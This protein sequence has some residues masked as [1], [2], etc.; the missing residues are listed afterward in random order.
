MSTAQ[1]SNI[2]SKLV[3]NVLSYPCKAEEDLFLYWCVQCRIVPPDFPI[4][5]WLSSCQ[6]MLRFAKNITNCLL[7]ISDSLSSDFERGLVTRVHLCTIGLHPLSVMFYFYIPHEHPRPGGHIST[8]FQQVLPM[9]P[10]PWHP[11]NWV[12]P[13]R[14]TRINWNYNMQH[15][16]HT[17]L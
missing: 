10:H 6:L 3:L 4:F 15:I 14:T 2:P 7:F 5:T 9:L 17:F 12:V 11:F 8:W 16:Y 1:S 13:N